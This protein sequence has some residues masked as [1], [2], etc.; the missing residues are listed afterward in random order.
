[1]GVLAAASLYPFKRCV[2]IELLTDLHKYSLKNKVTYEIEFEKYLKDHK[3][4]FPLH[5]KLPQIEF[6]H[7]SF[8][9]NDWANGSFVFTNSTTFDTKIMDEIFS[10]AQML[11]KGSFF[12]NTTRHFPKNYMNKWDSIKPFMRLMSWGCASLFIHRKR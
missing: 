4:L 10:R 7:G 8:L 3:H 9:D 6:I 5:E 12:T 2:G 11:K 1:M